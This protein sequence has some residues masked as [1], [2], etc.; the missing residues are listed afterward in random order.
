[1]RCN[2]IVVVG[3]LLA[4]SSYGSDRPA[5]S[6]KPEL[7]IEKVNAAGSIDVTLLPANSG[8]TRVWRPTN[9]WGAANWRVF[10]LRGEKVLLFR[11]DPDQVFWRNTRGFEELHAPKGISLNL[12]AETWIGPKNEFGEFQSGDRVLV[13]YDVPATPDAREFGVWY[14]TISAV[15]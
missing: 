13:V 11:E 3:L 7:R 10:I 14:G 4:V 5:P 15:T 2:A 12:L 9:S 6:S 1:M 8:S